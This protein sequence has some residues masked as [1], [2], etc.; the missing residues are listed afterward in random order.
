MHVANDEDN[1]ETFFHECVLL[2]VE[3]QRNVGIG[4][5]C[6]G[7]TTLRERKLSR[8]FSF[9]KLDGWMRASSHSGSF[10]ACRVSPK[11]V[12]RHFRELRRFVR[13]LFRCQE[14]LF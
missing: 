9:D 3:A 1:L 5:G 7:H 12:G 10:Q 8:G 11:I 6:I 14:A 13:Y 2:N 4:R